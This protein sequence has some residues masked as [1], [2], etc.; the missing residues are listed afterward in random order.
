MSNRILMSALV[1]LG[2]AVPAGAQQF[3]RDSGA[4]PAQNIWTDGVEVA[5]IDGD[6]DL[7][8]LFANGSTYG[9]GGFQPQ[10]LFRNNGSGVFSS[11]HGSLNVAN[12]NAKMVIAED[13]DGDGDLDLMY[14][15]E[16]PAASPTQKPR[17]L[18]NQGGMQGGTQG[19]FADE[20][21]TRLPNIFMASYCVAAGD[22]DDDGDLDVV[23]TDGATFSGLARQ[24]RLYENDGNG[25]FSDV[26][27]AQ[28][29]SDL[30]NA[31]DATLFDFDGD[32]DIDI[33]LSGKGGSGKRSRLYLN[34]G[35]GNFSISTI[36]NGVGTGATYE[37]DW[38][39]FDG[40]GDFDAA[41][42]SISGQ[43]E[44]WAL[45]N[46]TG[47]VMPE[48]TF[49]SPNGADDNEMACLDYDSD[50]DMDVMVASLGSTEKIYRNDGGGTWVNQQGQIQSISDSTLDFGFGDLD[51]D[52]D[53]D[54]VT[55]Q[56]ESGNFTNKVYDNNG[57]PDILPP[58]LLGEETVVNWGIPE[59]V[60]HIRCQDAISDDGHI[61]AT[62]DFNYTTNLG[63][64]TGTATHM[65]GGMF[66]ASVETV[67]GLHSINIEIDVTDSSGNVLSV[68]SELS[69]NGVWA[70]LGGGS[71]G[72]NGTPALEMSGPLTPGSLTTMKLSQAPAGAIL[73]FWLSFSEIP[74]PAL[75][76]TVYT[77]PFSTQ[78]L[79]SANGDGEFFASTNWPAG[80]PA[81]LTSSWQFVVE[82]V[83]TIYGA[84]LSNA[85]RAI[86]H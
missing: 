75:G 26:T 52:G 50:G 3:T 43:N 61:N 60:F 14:A 38:A 36:M 39:D 37:I 29:P 17:L 62:A 63:S 30:Y 15:A 67:P 77:L 44:G 56:G 48:A 71:S 31:Q 85:V 41:V 72:L 70:Y 22:V 49:P 13:F 18:I 54:M 4:L 12:F 19:I 28:M 59:T 73:V 55:G 81:G 64:G 68:D 1:L 46:G 53:Y 10:H 16:G 25:F 33:A 21:S 34:D 27:A 20:S 45:N 7:D 32:F 40:D 84:T 23:L 58:T 11:S 79:L 8:I 47:V 9:S 78:L 80:I 42:Q 57:S 6:G 76:G 35:E 69:E 83:S 82:D 24:A 2:A 66:R 51:G 74:T 65:G 5:D 86:A